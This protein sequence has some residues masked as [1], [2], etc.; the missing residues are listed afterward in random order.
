[1]APTITAAIE[2]DRVTKNFSLGLRL[3]SMRALDCFTLKVA[4]GEIVGLLGPNGSGKSTALRT[5]AGLLSPSDGL[6]R[7]Y[8]DLSTSPE[9]RAVLGYLPE[10]P[11]FPEHL[12]GTELV[13]YY[14]G[15]SGLAGAQLEQN[16]AK[17]LSQ[18]G[19]SASAA[20]HV[21]HYTKGMTQRLG[22]A[23]A[24]VH[25]PK[26]LLLDE[27]T[28]GVDPQG[29]EEMMDIFGRLKA[30]GRTI[31][32]TSHLLDQVGDI[33]D[34]I[35]ILA[36]GR[37]IFEGKADRLTEGR[38]GRDVFSTEPMSE[39]IRQE[40]AGWLKTRNFSLQ[41]G[42]DPAPRLDR[43]YLERVRAAGLEERD[44]P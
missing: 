5:A 9:A 13:R 42:G 23:Q 7:V 19:L 15:L 33:C 16:T 32:L 38:N 28:S 20:R 8:G 40:L 39:S 4:P 27:P 22:L 44:K 43:V 26:I 2:F 36:N 35:A 24:L 30:A 17:V 37:L 12:T 25:D 29:L 1:M 6:C 14:A 21:H 11:R 18:V 41:V 31:V 34:R 3:Q 10:S